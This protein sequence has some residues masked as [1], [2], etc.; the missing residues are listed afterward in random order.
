MILV[1][2][3][4][5]YEF[6]PV[7]TCSSV[8]VHMIPVWNVVP[9]WVHSGSH[10]SYRYEIWPHSVPVSCKAGTGFCSGTRWVAEL[11]GTG[12]ECQSIVNYAPKWLVRTKAQM[13]LRIIPVKWLPCKCGTK[14][15]FVPEWNSYQ[16]H[17]NTPLERH[18][19][20]PIFV[21]VFVWC[22]HDFN[23]FTAKGEF[24]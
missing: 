11:T 20:P 2:V 17:V 7:P 8:F 16:Y 15:D 24:D 4:F 5:Q 18:G 10:V 22:S 14:L 13:K 21:Y 1:Q 12:S 23:R 3:S 6:I 19:D 9:A